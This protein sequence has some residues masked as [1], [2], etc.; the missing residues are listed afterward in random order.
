MRQIKKT[1]LLHINMESVNFA[2]LGDEDV[3]AT[4]G[5]SGTAT[6]LALFDRKES[7]II[8]TWA[9][10]RGFPEKIQSLLQAI[11]LGEYAV[12]HVKSLDRFAGEQILALDIMGVTGGI[13]SHTHNVDHDSLMQAV[14]GT[15]VEKY[16]FSELTNL[17]EASNKFSPLLRHGDARVVID[18]S[19]E[20]RGAGTIILGKVVSGR[21]SKYDEMVLSPSGIPVTI[22]SIQMHDDPVDSAHSPARVG[23]VLK[24]V[25]P[26]DIFRGYMLYAK[27][28]PPATSGV[29]LDFI[30]TPFYKRKPEVGQTCMFSVGMQV[31][32]ARFKSTNPVALTLDRPVVCMQ[33][34]RCAILKPDASDV[35]IMGG[36]HI[37]QCHE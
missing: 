10:P 25:R 2:F 14:H 26:Q 15:V 30:K 5:K 36:G 18:H 8:R 3:A 11:S 17:R 35:R 34:D 29:R 27:D 31:V 21:I 16:E 23:L 37:L 6:D 24:G 32:P 12:L 19:F 9:V 7:G 1:V 4:L 33:S 20:G 22:K 13:L 28:A